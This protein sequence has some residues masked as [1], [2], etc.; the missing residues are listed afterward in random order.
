MCFALDYMQ[1]Q[2]AIDKDEAIMK[3]R[4]EQQKNEQLLIP[5]LPAIPKA[6]QIPLGPRYLIIFN[7]KW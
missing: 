5:K 1:E 2:N 4:E 7:K 6:L 3:A